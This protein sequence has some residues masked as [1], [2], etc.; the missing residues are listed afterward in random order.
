M[1]PETQAKA[2]RMLDEQGCLF[3]GTD[4]HHE[5]G[6]LLPNIHHAQEPLNATVVVIGEATCQ[7]FCR[8]HEQYHGPMRI[9]CPWI[10]HYKVIAE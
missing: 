7:E 2:Q 4:Q 3:V 10:Y 1:T 8:Q 5:I 9:P 6:D